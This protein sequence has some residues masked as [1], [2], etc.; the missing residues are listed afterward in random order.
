MLK[1]KYIE[2]INEKNKMLAKDGGIMAFVLVNIGILYSSIK[3]NK[4]D[5]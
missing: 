4:C 1:I 2:L 3:K 5:K